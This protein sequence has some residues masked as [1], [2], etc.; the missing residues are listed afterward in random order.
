[1]SAPI[2]PVE[3]AMLEQAID[4]LFAEYPEL[5]E[6]SALRADVLEGETNLDDVLSRILER[7]READAAG[8]SGR[9]QSC[10]CQSP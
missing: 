5:A 10:L 1:M 7:E 2:H 8:Q 9:T 4:A 3:I 6:D